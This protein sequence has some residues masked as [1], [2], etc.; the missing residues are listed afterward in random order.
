MTNIWI[1]K[2]S[3]D[4][5]HADI[6]LCSAWWKLIRERYGRIRGI[7]NNLP[8]ILY[9]SQELYSA[10]R[11]SKIPMYVIKVFTLIRQVNLTRK[12]NL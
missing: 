1:K 6:L 5:M 12:F 10:L 2:A 9:I 8:T 7:E 11:Y 3:R 4:H